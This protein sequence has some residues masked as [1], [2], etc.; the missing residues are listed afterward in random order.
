[1]RVFFGSAETR[2]DTGWWKRPDEDSKAVPQV[3]FV[4]GLAPSTLYDVEVDG[5]EMDD[6]RT[7]KAGILEL[8]FAPEHHAGVR[9]RKAFI[10]K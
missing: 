3:A 1:V 7:D 9:V 4:V 2:F 6:D 10:E 8:R 5:E